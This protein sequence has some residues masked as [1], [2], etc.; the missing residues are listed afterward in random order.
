MPILYTGSLPVASP[1]QVTRGFS[2]VS[3]GEL[4]SRIII[5]G[6]DRRTAINVA[7]NSFLYKYSH[8]I[9]DRVERRVEARGKGISV[10]DLDVV[11]SHT[12]AASLCRRSDSSCNGR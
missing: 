4:L 3:N 6:W 5:T 2:K 1:L 7:A 8:E 9:K 10:K 12:A 11:N